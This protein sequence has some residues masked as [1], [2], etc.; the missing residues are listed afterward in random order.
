VRLR[1]SDGPVDPHQPVG[2]SVCEAKEKIDQVV[3]PSP[4]SG[5]ASR[6]LYLKIWRR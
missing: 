5:V 3:T 4:V 2:A 1:M 6:A